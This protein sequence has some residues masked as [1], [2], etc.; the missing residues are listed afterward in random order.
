MTISS[1]DICYRT[2]KEVLHAERRGEI[3][4]V[5][6]HLSVGE[7]LMPKINYQRGESREFVRR[8]DPGV[9]GR[10]RHRLL[11]T[12]VGG[13]TSRGKGGLIKSYRVA[14]SENIGVRN[15]CPCC[16]DA[17]WDRRS[18]SSSTRRRGKRL[19]HRMLRNH[20][21]MVCREELQAHHDTSRIRDEVI[22]TH[23]VI[24]YCAHTDSRRTEL[25]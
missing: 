18:R 14:K 24:T 12:R 13:Q 4:V 19:T 16:V 22:D 11:W 2:E 9:A 5:D 10:K 21:R 1:L 25:G 8:R 7:L 15:W 17:L 23:G 3:W 20:D 6:R